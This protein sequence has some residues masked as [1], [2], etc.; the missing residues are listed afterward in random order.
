MEETSKPIT[1]A[2]AVAKNIRVSAS[3]M[4]RVVDLV[5]GKSVREAKAILKFTPNGSSAIVAK[6]LASAVAN[7][8][9]NAKLSE[10][11]LFVRAIFVDEGPTMKRYLPRAKGSADRLL[12]RSSH[13]TVIVGL[14][15]EA[16]PFKKPAK[17]AEAVQAAAEAN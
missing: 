13:L 10:D 3:K 16:K 2:Q 15:P 17:K 4:R 7:A 1:E 12:K 14:A 11:A 8:T 5:R 6:T 9:T